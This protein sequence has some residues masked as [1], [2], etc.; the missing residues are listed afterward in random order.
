MSKCPVVLMILD[1]WGEREA[2]PD[3]AITVAQPDEFLALRQKYPHTLLSCS[4]N[5]VGLPVGQMGNSEVGH[6]NI[7]AGRVVYQ[8]ITRISKAI[9]DGEFF[10]NSSLVATM[11]AARL[12]NSSLHL[13]GLLSDGGVHSHIEHLYALLEMAKQQ[14]VEQVF[15]H[16]F[17]DGRDVPPQSASLYISLLEDF[18][19]K[20]TIG[21]FATVGGRYFGMDRDKHWDRIEKAYNAMTLG[22]GNHFPTAEAVVQNGYASEI[23][24]EFIEPANIVDELGKPQGLIKDQDSIIFFNFRAD[25]A[26]QISHT[27]VDEEFNY[28]FRPRLKNINY[29][30][31]TQYDVEL[32]AEVAFKPQNLRNTL[33]EYLAHQ[34]LKQL[35]IAETEKYAHLTFFFN[36]GIEKP[37]PQE[38][39][40]LIPSPPVA[41][42]DMQP[43]MSAV[44][45]TERVLQEIARDYYDVIMIN[46][47]NPDMVGH[48]GNLEAAVQ[49]VKTVDKCVGKIVRCVVEKNGVIMITADHGNCEKMV[50]EASSSPHTAHTTSPVPFILVSNEHRNAILREGGALKDIAPTLLQVLRIPQP[51]EMEGISL[52]DT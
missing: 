18:M 16:A 43:E 13:M 10:K 24:D 8:E 4:G 15:I 28:F 23:T 30:C 17:L 48:T 47:A 21:K 33:G 2:V 11:Q 19:Q 3:N 31:M 46:F 34:G 14:G 12:N 44:E 29:L 20:N 22:T 51:N 50:D 38:E 41:T 45:I 25:R 9:T 39:R 27:F 6:L 32:N 1:G 52:L 5:E 26:R 37:N 40:I 7:G 35:R 49:A 42:Y 36:G